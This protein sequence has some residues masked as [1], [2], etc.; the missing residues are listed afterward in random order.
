MDYK[1]TTYKGQT[2]VRVPADYDYSSDKF[3][4]YFKDGARS[5]LIYTPEQLIDDVAANGYCENFADMLMWDKSSLQAMTTENV[6]SLIG[7]RI[8]FFSEQYHANGDIEGIGTIT[9]VDLSQ[10]SI[11][12]GFD[13]EEGEDVMR[14]A[15]V[16]WDNNICLGDADRTIFVKVL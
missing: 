3:Q 2:I 12:T 7:K 15:F 13:F 8:Y 11:I 10:R 16:G 5:K 6:S 9:A 14:F 4:V 1:R